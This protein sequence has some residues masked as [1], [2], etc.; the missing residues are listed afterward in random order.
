MN[1]QLIN[2][3]CVKILTK[4][5]GILTDPWMFGS[6]FNN[7][8]NL[9]EKNQTNTTEILNKVNYIWLSHEHPDHFDVN[10][11]NALLLLPL[12]IRYL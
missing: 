8:W 1:V 11:F 3:A 4:D 7:G 10:F 12:S 9:I 5:C 6:V 2:H